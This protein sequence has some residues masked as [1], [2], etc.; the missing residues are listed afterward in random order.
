MQAADKG[1]LDDEIIVITVLR[2]DG[3]RLRK[4]RAPAVAT[5]ARGAPEARAMGRQSGRVQPEVASRGDSSAAGRAPSSAGTAAGSSGARAT[6]ESDTSAART[7]A[8]RAPGGG[9]LSML[10]ARMRPTR[11][12]STGPEGFFIVTDPGPDPDDIKGA[13]GAR[14]RSSRR[15]PS[16]AAAAAADC[17]RVHSR[18]VRATFPPNAHPRP[19]P[20]P[21]ARAPPS[22]ADRRHSAPAAADSAARRRGQRCVR[23]AAH[24]RGGGAW[25]GVA[26]AWRRR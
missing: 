19:P 16:A 23:T 26:R 25:V 2:S 15:Q 20:P 13:R 11:R 9:V 6:A 4:W 17:A 3:A 12:R 8:E 5:A 22:P 24:G 21:P 18:G 1:Y 7:R 10:G 14:P